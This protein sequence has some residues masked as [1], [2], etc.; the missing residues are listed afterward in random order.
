MKKHYKQLTLE[1]REC[2]YALKEKGMSSRNVLM[3]L[4][5]NYRTIV[6]EFNRNRMVEE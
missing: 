3:I 5:R 2:I 4:G 6:K 1:E